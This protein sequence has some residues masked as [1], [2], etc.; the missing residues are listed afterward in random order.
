MIHR[1]IRSR[2]RTL[3][4]EISPRG[5]LIVRA[6]L[7]FP[8]YRIHQF[9]NEKQFWIERFQEKVKKHHGHHQ[10]KQFVA[11]EE[12]LYLGKKY[13]LQLV[14]GYAVTVNSTLQFPHDW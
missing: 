9:I 4:L 7:R 13:P 11:G 8:L 6:P 10:P 3:A 1:L 2:R 12:F 5:E 14:P